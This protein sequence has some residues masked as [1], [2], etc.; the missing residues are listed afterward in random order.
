MRRFIRSKQIYCLILAMPVFF[1]ALPVSH[2]GDIVL[3]Y[4]N[5]GQIGIEVKMVEGCSSCNQTGGSLEKQ[6]SCFC[7]DIPISRGAVEHSTLLPGGTS[8]GKPHAELQSSSGESD[9]FSSDKK[10]VLSPLP[11]FTRSI[12]ESLRTTVLLI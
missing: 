11:S 6:N 12:H 5:A 9:P 2:A 8:Q 3:C 4:K 10:S 7:V 1:L